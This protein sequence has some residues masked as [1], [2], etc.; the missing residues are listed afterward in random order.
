MHSIDTLTLQLVTEEQFASLNP[1]WQQLLAQSGADSLFLSWHWAHSW[2]SSFRQPS[3]ELNL[4]TATN[5]EGE[6]VALAPLYSAKVS[7]RTGLNYRSLQFIGTRYK[8][9][10]G[11]RSECLEFL[12]NPNYP[13]AAE[14]LVGY[15]RQHCRYHLLYLS[16]LMLSSSTAAAC[17]RFFPSIYP[18]SVNQ[19]Y[20]I[21][22]TA[23]FDS[24]LKQ[25]GKNTRLRGYNRRTLLA[26]LGHFSIEQNTHADIEHV[27]STLSRYHERRWT[28][29]LNSAKHQRFMT[30]LTKSNHIAFSGSTLYLD[31]NAIATSLDLIAGMRC[32]NI[33]LGFNDS[34]SKKI[35]LGLI[36]L[37]YCIERCFASDLQHYDLLTGTGKKAD[38]KPRMSVA[39]RQFQTLVIP[40]STVLRLLFYV[41][42]L[43]RKLFKR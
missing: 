6:M 12:I 21:D 14:Q 34:I 9:S 29:D 4:I 43:A 17:H 13:N 8:G 33:Q 26:N 11:Y 7:T 40:V 31:E 32:Y 5:K 16:D 24:Y 28:S 35:S 3:D 1:A 2:W 15:I 22:T 19:T 37:F 25:L 27:F 41:K 18:D 30:L 36:T 10:S 23:E 20:A 39:D 38:Y 42:N